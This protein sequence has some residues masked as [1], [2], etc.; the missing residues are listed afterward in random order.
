VYRYGKSAQLCAERSITRVVGKHFEAE[1]QLQMLH[2]LVDCSSDTAGTDVT[3][4]T[5]IWDKQARKHSLTS[6]KLTPGGFT[7]AQY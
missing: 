2:P 5:A 7:P 3:P 6:P 4:F 1:A